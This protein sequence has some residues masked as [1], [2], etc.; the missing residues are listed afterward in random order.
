M[1]ASAPTTL[2]YVS[3]WPAK[4]ACG[5]S[6]AVAEERTATGTPSPKASYAAAIARARSSGTLASSSGSRR[7][8]ELRQARGVFG[9]RPGQRGERGLQAGAGR[10]QLVGRRGHAEPAGTGSPARTISPRFAALPPTT[11]SIPLP[12]AAKGSMNSDLRSRNFEFS[13]R[14]TPSS[15]S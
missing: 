10:H 2:R 7:R 11:G 14:S 3:C 1:T 8:R 5:R 15:N 13:A 12:I 9:A 6:S 4:L